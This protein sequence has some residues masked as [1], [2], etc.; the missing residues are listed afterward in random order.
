V[1]KAY[2]HGPVDIFIHPKHFKKNSRTPP[3]ALN[4]HRTHIPLTMGRRYV[5]GLKHRSTAPDKL[6]DS[7]SARALT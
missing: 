3:D 6:P 7:R 5:N 1:S 2:L 4:M